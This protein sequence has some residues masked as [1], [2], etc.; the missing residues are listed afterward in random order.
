MNNVFFKITCFVLLS[1]ILCSCQDNNPSVALLVQA[2]KL[3]NNNPTEALILLDSIQ[4]DNLDEDKYM[5]YIIARVQAK[6]KNNKSIVEDTLIFDARDYFETKEN[7]AQSAL[8]HFYSGGV[9]SQK[10]MMGKALKSYMEAASYAQLSKDTILMARSQYNIGYQYY[11]QDVMDSAISHYKKA[12]DIFDKVRDVD[13]L[14]MQAIHSMGSALFS[15]Y[16]LDSSYYYINKGLNLAKSTNNQKYQSIFTKNLGIIDRVRGDYTEAKTKLYFSLTQTTSSLDSLRIYLNL[17]KLYNTTEQLD[18]AHYYTDLLKNRLS[19]I[20]DKEVILGTYSSLSEYNKL[21]GNYIDALRYADL[22]SKMKENIKGESQLLELLSADKEYVLGLKN[23]EAHHFRVQV[24]FWSMIG[25]I[26]FIA[27][28]IL[29][30]SLSR[31]SK[32]DKKEIELQAQKYRNIKE[33]LISMGAEYKDIEAE[34]ASMLNDED[35]EDN[36]KE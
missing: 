21:L 15:N 18:S 7:F 28:L 26:V 22:E 11:K 24:L 20:T 30:L 9:Y 1:V 5:Q 16:D 23:K 36:K 34:I 32:R 8:A 19:E 33:Q 12:L 25:G 2:Q 13:T 4:T 35:E 17:A 10:N 6:Y 3:A 14:K 27:L 29:S 31:I